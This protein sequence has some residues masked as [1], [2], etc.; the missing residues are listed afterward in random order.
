[1]ASWVFAALP[2]PSGSKASHLRSAPLV[3]LYRRLLYVSSAISAPASYIVPPVDP[4]VRLQVLDRE[5][6]RRLSHSHAFAL[7]HLRHADADISRDAD[8]T[9]H[10]P[11]T[12]VR[13]GPRSTRPYG[14]ALRKR[15]LETGWT[16]G[17]QL[18][19]Q[20]I[21]FSLNYRSDQRYSCTPVVNVSTAS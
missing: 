16:S 17:F 9:V 3:L 11:S 18:A 14:H 7:L 12:Y 5:R 21:A 4:N 20:R 6:L 8:R 10:L 1:V 13:Y 15:V 19:S 2:Q